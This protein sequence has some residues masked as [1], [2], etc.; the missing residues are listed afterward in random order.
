ME[1][2]FIQIDPKYRNKSDGDHCFIH[3]ISW[4]EGKKTKSYFS[5][6]FFKKYSDLQFTSVFFQCF[7][8]KVQITL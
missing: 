6:S 4:V 8:D 7:R 2:H 3:F 1:F 5:M